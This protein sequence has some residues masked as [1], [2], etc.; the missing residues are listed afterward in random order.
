LKTILVAEDNEAIRGTVVDLLREAGY[1]V[2][3]AESGN[4]ALL[5]LAVNS[6]DLILSDI[7]MPDGDG[8]HLLQTVRKFP[9]P[10]PLVFVSAN[11]CITSSEIRLRGA[12]A[13]FRKPVDTKLL[14]IWIKSQFEKANWEHF[15]NRT[16]QISTNS[17]K[18]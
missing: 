16:V 1:M 15:G 2:L 14:L 17:H 8:F 11:P 3:E 4:K 13:L 6:V 7:Q 9:C 10:I 5:L 18:W 12:L